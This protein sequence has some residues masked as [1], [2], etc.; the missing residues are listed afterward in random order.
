MAFAS[1]KLVRGADKLYDF[2]RVTAANSSHMRKWLSCLP[3]YVCRFT[4]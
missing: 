3:A 2:G 4:F 1:S